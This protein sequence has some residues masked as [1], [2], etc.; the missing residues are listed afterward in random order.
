MKKTIFTLFSMF[1]LLTIDGF[2]QLESFVL[3]N[4]ENGQV[5]FTSE[6]H[7]NPAASMDIA[8][9]DNPV[10]DAVNS[11]NKVWEWRR[12]DTGDNQKWAGFWAILTN[13]VPNGYHK[14]EMKF[15]RK[16][17]TS[18]LRI[19]CEGAIS[20]E[21]NPVAPATKTNEWETLTFDIYSNG[22]KNVRVLGMFPDYYDPIDVNAVTYIDD[23]KFIY[24]PSIT[25]P[26]AP[27]SIVLFDD[28]PD[29]RF[30][31]NSWSP[32]AT[33][34]STL[35]LEHWKGA[36]IP[37][38]DKFPVVTA[39]KK[40]GENALKL[41]W[42]SVNGGAWSILAASVGWKALDVSQMTHF[43]FWVN[44]PS[45]LSKST[46]PKIFLE[47]HSG[48][49][50]K[51]GKLEM[52]NYID[53]LAANKWTEVVVPLEDFWNANTEFTSKDVIKG[54]FFEQSAADNVQHTLFMDDFTFNRSIV[55][56][57][58]VSLMFD[59][60]SNN[61]SLQTEGNWN[62]IA[63]HQAADVAL[64]DNQGN[65]TGFTLKVTDPFFKGYNTSGSASPSG[66]AAIFAYTATNDNFFG[67]GAVW[68]NTDA[69]P[70]GVFTING[71]DTDKYYS[72][73][74]F[75]SRM[76]VSDIR[77]AKYTVLGKNGEQ[78]QLLNA[79]N[80]ESN[81]AIINNVMPTSEGMI[82]I[83]TEAGPNNNNAQKF[84]FIGA[85]E[86][87]QHDTPSSIDET[88]RKKTEIYYTNNT[89][90]L[91]GYTGLISVYNTL[92]ARVTTGKSQQGTL[93]LNLPNGIYIVRTT[94]GSCKIIIK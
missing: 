46:L 54:I 17:A 68:G 50:N 87:T 76:S 14:V 53:D 77:E 91:D 39:P 19:K 83:K 88:S 34:P 45:A 73:T 21:I 92:G 33:T 58:E 78:S 57:G 52:G 29:N 51:S 48:N 36:E 86:M 30:Y 7:I 18:Q 61:A 79:S 40:S 32:K 90:Y 9:V 15:L 2:A 59:F 74:I 93:P 12:Y 62:N 23:I 41:E 80:N 38:G 6:V 72:F 84:Y 66:D 11:S 4:F 44:S 37:D 81:V 71:L 56:P 60:G 94:N 67:N 1:F 22:I 47:A 82:T 16:N 85:M 10:K 35:L 49:P 27:T 28:S 13:E 89:L 43:K 55:V 75:A 64:I 65:N 8:V 24:D 26:P 69:N 63:D 31:D 42:K 20:K 5:N 3:D 25:P 70:A